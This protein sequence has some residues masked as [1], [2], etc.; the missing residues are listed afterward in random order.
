MLILIN[1][2][3][4]E[5]MIEGILLQLDR[6]AKSKEVRD[7]AVQIIGYDNDIIKSIHKWVKDNVRYIQDPVQTDGFIELFI[8]PVK[9]VKDYSEGKQIAG[10]CDDMAILTTSLY[11]AVGLSANVCLLSTGGNGLDH[12]VCKVWSE[13][14]G[15]YLMVD[16]SASV[17]CGWEEK[18]SETLMV[19]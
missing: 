8:S 7:L 17:P 15:K 11:R 9:M 2:Y 1:G 16:P 4:R 12:A 3:S 19:V 5:D 18:S 6:A 10:D 14:L 13:R